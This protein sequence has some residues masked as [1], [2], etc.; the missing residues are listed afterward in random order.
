MPGAL[1]ERLNALG[2]CTGAVVSPERIAALSRALHNP[3]RQPA[4]VLPEHWLVVVSQT[5]DVLARKLEQEPYLELLHCRVIPKLRSQF[6]ELRSTRTLDFK[7]D[8][9]RQPNLCLTAHA[10]ADRYLV[11][12][13]MFAKFAPDPARSLSEAARRRVLA[14]YSLRY[15]R[16]TWPDAF[17]RR[18]SAVAKELEQ[19]LEPI[20][21]DDMAEVRVSLREWDCELQDKEPYHLEVYFVID[22]AHWRTNEAGRKS[23]HAAFANFVSLLQQCV[24][25]DVDMVASGVLS[26]DEFTWQDTRETDQWDFANLTHRD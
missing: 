12:R 15:G 6:K 25:V 13:E 7:P 11:P 18:V 23:V 26:G 19:A 9:D 16:P 14:W 3:R 17:V 8:K 4:D 1:G 20:V 24:G 21:E 2:W 5:C 10:V 22:A